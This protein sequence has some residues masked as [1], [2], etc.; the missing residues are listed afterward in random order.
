MKN[1]KKIFMFVFIFAFMLLLTACGD[2]FKVVFDE[3]GGTEV[4]DVVVKLEELDKFELPTTTKEGYIFV[5]WYLDK[6]YDKSFD[7]A[8]L[9]KLLEEEKTLTLYARWIEEL[10]DSFAITLKDSESVKALIN[11]KDEYTIKLDAESSFK[12]K[13]FKIESLEDLSKL[14]CKLSLSFV[15]QV[16]A[17]DVDQEYNVGIVLTLKNGELIIELSDGLYSLLQTLISNGLEMTIEIPQQLKFNL[18]AIIETVKEVINNN[19]EIKDFL[20]TEG[21]SLEEVIEAIKEGLKPYYESYV[22]AFEEAGIDEAVIDEFKTA[23]AKLMPTKE[24]VDGKIV[25][26]ITDEQFKAA[27]DELFALVVKYYNNIKTLV[28]NLEDSDN[29]KGNIYDVE[30]GGWYQD[31]EFHSFAEDYF[32]QHGY[33]Y[34]EL[35]IYVCYYLQ[36][37]IFM[38]DENYKGYMGRPLYDGYV[39]FGEEVVHLSD[40]TT[41]SLEED[42]QKEDSVFGYIKEI[43]GKEYYYISSNFVYQL[44]PFKALTLEEIAELEKAT[45]EKEANENKELLKEILTINKFEAICDKEGKVT[46]SVDVTLKAPEGDDSEVQ[47]INIV[48]EKVLSIEISRDTPEYDDITGYIADYTE[49]IKM[50]LSSLTQ[51]EKFPVITD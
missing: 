20:P 28:E 23:L 1:I 5:G 3:Q 18:V 48:Y 50:L 16:K 10:S 15:L 46:L 51:P 43:N 31:G 38:I 7:L 24:E 36:D 21:D 27:I 49:I 47:E 45:F 17:G 22:K 42:A 44:S 13:Y 30:K 39:L 37:Y 4:E 9:K 35:G 19:E 2:E 33:K 6:D 32:G 41:K 34:D 8:S 12:A 40:G 29:E 25:L 26:T 14:D 11:G